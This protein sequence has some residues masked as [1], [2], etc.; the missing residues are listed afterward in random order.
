M[1]LF[2]GGRGE[3]THAFNHLDH[4]LLALPLLAAGSGHIDAEGFG[5]IEKRFAWLDSRSLLV[6]DEVKTH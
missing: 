4:A 1:F 5:I 3:A 6:K 2:R